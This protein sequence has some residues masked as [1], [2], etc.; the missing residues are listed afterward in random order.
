MGWLVFIG[1]LAFFAYQLWKV[2][3]DE[4]GEPAIQRNNPGKPEYKTSHYNDEG[5]SNYARLSNQVLP[6]TH[7]WRQ[8]FGTCDLAG[9]HHHKEAFMEYTKKA[10]KA[11]LLRK[12]HGLNFHRDP[13]NP[14]D[15][16]AIEVHGWVDEPSNETLIGFVPADLALIISDIPDAP[17]TGK[18]HGIKTRGEYIDAYIIVMFPGKR[19]S[20]WEGRDDCPF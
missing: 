14:H 18:L 9:L 8:L 4:S 20:F 11:D 5:A 7:K 2:L 16:N 17:I 19:D 10:L 3:A 12:P 6:D 1:I 15:K 13:Y